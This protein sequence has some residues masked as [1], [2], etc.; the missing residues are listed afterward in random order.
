MSKN[1]YV[2]TILAAATLA[3]GLTGP[4]QAVP[5]NEIIFH[6][7]VCGGNAPQAGDPC[8][9]QSVTSPTAAPELL[10]GIDAAFDAHFIGITAPTGPWSYSIV[11]ATAAGYILGNIGDHTYTYAQGTAYIHS[12]SFILYQGHVICCQSTEPPADYLLSINDNGIALARIGVYNAPGIMNAGGWDPIL[13]NLDAESLAWFGT[14]NDI[15]PHF[16]Q[17]AYLFFGNSQLLAID[18]DNRIS[19]VNINFGEFLLSPVADPVPEP[20]S[21]AML[22]VPF[23]SLFLLLKRKKQPNIATVNPSRSHQY[24]RV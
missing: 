6:L 17:E 8:Y 11:G 3:A 18:D 4:A 12:T 10:N 21:L 15:A 24:E 23:F 1:P 22:L 20:S 5:V 19:G 14:E 16:S 2:S 13:P 7:T 9:V